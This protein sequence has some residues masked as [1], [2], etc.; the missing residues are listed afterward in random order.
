[1]NEKQKEESD[2]QQVPRADSWRTRPRMILNQTLS[3]SSHSNSAKNS[4]QSK[5]SSSFSLVDASLEKLSDRSTTTDKSLVGPSKFS[6]S[7]EDIKRV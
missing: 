5:D 2:K 3:T 6:A 1:M 7:K 4:V